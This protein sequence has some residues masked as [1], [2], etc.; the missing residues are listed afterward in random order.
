M[1]RS[2]ADYELIIVT[3]G[4]LY[5]ADNEHRFEVN[6]G[7]YIILPPTTHQYGYQK[8]SCSFYWFHFANG[9]EESKQKTIVLPQTGTVHNLSHISILFSQFHHLIGNCRDD[10]TINLSATG[11]LLALSYSNTQPDNASL[12]GFVLYQKILEYIEWNS[13]YNIS[14]LHIAKQLGYHPK[15]IS[16]IF[17][18]FHNST[19]K[20]YL[21]AQTMDHAKSR[22]AYSTQSITEIAESMGFCD[23]HNFS[24]SFRRVVGVSPR[25]Y[26]N[27]FGKISPNYM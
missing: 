6:E 23:V 21:L 10:Y 25:E 3:E 19:L 8:S 26:R 5:I 2:L 1:S 9:K 20:Q 27:S 12:T 22:L 11:I 24:S 15:Y 18:R 7:E 13:G 16:Q 4:V 17:H 14:V